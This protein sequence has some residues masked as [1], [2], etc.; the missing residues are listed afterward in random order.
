MDYCAKI[1]GLR[2]VSS[3]LL[4][5]FVQ[6]IVFVFGITFARERNFFFPFCK[7]KT[8]FSHEGISARGFRNARWRYTKP[9]V[10]KL[11]IM[12]P[13]INQIQCG[14]HFVKGKIHLTLVSCYRQI[15]GE[16]KDFDKSVI[17]KYSFDTQ[18]TH[19]LVSGSLYSVKKFFNLAS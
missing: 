13:E 1:K 7:E 11:S 16:F 6:V 5:F 9:C 10:N 4:I 19:T 14:C 3:F 15:E 8:Q 12:E 18:L 2:I 17:L